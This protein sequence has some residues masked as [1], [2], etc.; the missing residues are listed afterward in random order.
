ML[1]ALDGI[2]V[3]IPAFNAAA[4]LRETVASIR[5]YLDAAGVTYEI[6][7]V[8]DGSTDGTRDCMPVADGAVRWI[9]HERNF[10]KGRAVRTGML[11]AQYDWA[12]F[13]DAD[14]A[15]TIDHLAR[16][17]AEAAEC[18]IL[19]AS[20]RLAASRILCPQP[21]FRQTL[22]RMF[23]YLVKTWVLPTFEDTQC[24][25]KLFRKAAAADLFGRAGVDRFAFDVEILAMAVARRWR[26]REIAVDWR[27][28]GSG[29]TL[30]LRRDTMR[31]FLDV[32]KIGWR[33]RRGR[34]PTGRDHPE[35]R[36]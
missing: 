2:S 15:T 12:L 35:A 18:D 28:P 34:Y 25:F 36:T 10:G 11:A 20:R 3:I 8:D 5:D 30:S 16:F 4:Y 17:G 33:L 31:M 23:P 21:W 27:N 13:T 22:G 14:N 6:I 26:V 29:S 7:V 19:I 1:A 9:R 32:L 24:G